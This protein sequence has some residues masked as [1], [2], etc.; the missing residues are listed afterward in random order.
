MNVSYGTL[1]DILPGVRRLVANNPSP[2]TFKGTNTYVVGE[3]YVAIIDPGPDDETH[4]KSLLDALGSERITDIVITH[5]HRDHC[6]GVA[7][8][9]ALTGAQI[10][11]FGPT[12]APRGTKSQSPSASDFVNQDIAPDVV[13]ADKDLLEGRNWTLEAIHTPGHAP[14]HLCFSLTVEQM[15]SQSPRGGSVLFSGDH[16]MGWNTSVIAPPEGSMR[17][18]IR[19]LEKLRERDETLYLPGH[20]GRINNAKRVVKAYL[21]HRMWREASIRRC[22]E[23]GQNTIPQV[24]ETLYC[25]IH[26]SV[27]PAAALSVL[28]HLEFL[29]ERGVV[30]CQEPASLASTFSLT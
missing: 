7:R 19:S 30:S 9:Q 12:T 10:C 15:T 21:V 2:F 3:G 18:Y 20:G 27:M 1:Q 13:L 23:A 22:L 29:I 6:D 11:G 5:T 25:G 28:A 26:E 16:V 17:A 8:L 14:D 24:L 4:V